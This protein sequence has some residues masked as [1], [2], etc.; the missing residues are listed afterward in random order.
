MPLRTLDRG[1]AGAHA[2]RPGSAGR[3]ASSACS[4]GTP[5][6]I[7]LAV[8][9]SSGRAGAACRRPTSASARDSGRPAST[10]TLSRSSRSGSSRA[11]CVAR[12]AGSGRASSRSG[13]NQ[14]AAGSAA[15][16][17]TG[18]PPGQRRGDG[19][20]GQQ[21]DERRAAL[22]GH[23][24]ADVEAERR[25]RR[26]DPLAEVARRLGRPEAAA[27]PREQRD[28]GRPTRRPP[29]RRP[30]PR[31]CGRGRAR[32]EP[33]AP[34]HAGAPPRGTSARRSPLPPSRAGSTSPIAESWNATAQPSS[35]APSGAR[36]RPARYPGLASSA[37]A[38]RA[39]AAGR[40]PRR[41]R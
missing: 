21:R 13:A 23:H 25:A 1:H 26:L 36:T 31:G 33:R 41:A 39:A 11:M 6:A 20:A 17:T 34:R 10:L 16:A 12:A 15:A 24:V 29:G 7:S 32:G 27:D 18:Q 40:R 30:A 2:G 19:R 37:S 38:G 14:P 35:Q 5:S 9:P 28:R 4:R 22:D 3:S 8:R